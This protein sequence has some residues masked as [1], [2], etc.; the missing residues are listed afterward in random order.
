M[1]LWLTAMNVYQVCTLATIYFMVDN[2]IFCTLAKFLLKHKEYQCIYIFN[3]TNLR[4]VL[5]GNQ[6]LMFFNELY[7]CVDI[8]WH[9]IFRFLAQKFSK[10]SSLFLIQALKLCSIIQQ[11]EITLHLWLISIEDRYIYGFPLFCRYSFASCK[12]QS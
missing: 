2:N 7:A 10:W 6:T 9:L 8:H 11:L 12:G 5:R 4:E 1:I 3:Y